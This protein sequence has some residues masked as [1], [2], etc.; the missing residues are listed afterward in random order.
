MF[1]GHFAV[2]FG[3]KK[4]APG[5]SLG[6]LFLA[7][8]FADALWPIL[9]LSGV[10]RVRVDPGN[11]RFTPLDFVSYPWSHSLVMD[12]LWATAFALVYF[13]VR[14][15]RAGA[16]AVWICVLSHWILD[17][18]TH[19][20]DM[21]LSP[22]SSRKLGLGLWNSVPGTLAAES[23]MFLLGVFLYVRSTQARDR[24]G[25][26]AL[27]G[28]VAVLVGLYAAASA[29]TPPPSDRVV[30]GADLGG[31]LLIVWAYWVDGHRRAVQAS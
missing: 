27:W 6:T 31:V 29:G 12:L 2:G 18:V 19:R 5:T 26:W 15:Y 17:F 9:V 10:E 7:A 16:I 8:S 30:A 13:L 23:L 3:S 11:T 22:W 1:I 24:T 21:P 4:F 20:P 28:L 14:N 25:T